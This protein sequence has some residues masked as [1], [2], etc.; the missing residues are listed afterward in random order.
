MSTTTYI[1]REGS[2]ATVHVMGLDVAA[3]SEQE[4]VEYVLEAV[5][6]G[7][8]G[9]ICTANLDI[10]RQ[11]RESADLRELVSGADLVVADG[12]PLVW[13]GELQ[14]SPL[15]ERVAGSA[16]ILSLTAAA[17]K[18]GASVFLLGGNPG[19]AEAAA[20]ELLNLSPEL[21]VA[22]TLCPP[23]GFDRQPESFDR[24][25]HALSRTAADIV[26][27]GLGFPKQERLIVELR[28][29]MPETWFVPCGISFSLVAGEFK[30]APAVARRLGLE[31]L[32]RLVQEPKR[33][34]RRY[35]LQGIPFLVALLWSALLVRVS[36]AGRA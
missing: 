14:G 13:A 9:W 34:Y 22:G 27:V 32:Y 29:R 10:L 25:A 31:W 4:T 28:A 12:M 33:L 24:L 26:Y 23:F 19:T 7:R 21:R 16:L 36:A 6:R 8:G 17:A 1:R 20:T 11:W 5:G 30:R 3:V 18:T 15:P 35:M 2:P